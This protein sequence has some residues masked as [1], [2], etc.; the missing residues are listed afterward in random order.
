MRHYKVP[1]WIQAQQVEQYS[2]TK[3]NVGYE[4]GYQV[5]I[6]IRHANLK[7]GSGVPEHKEQ[8]KHQLLL[9]SIS[10]LQL[11]CVKLR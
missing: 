8:Y 3:Y 6:R 7:F 10:N 9:R 1:A 5:P 4:S 2:N 11:L